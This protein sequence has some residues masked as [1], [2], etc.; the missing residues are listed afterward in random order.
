M[1]TKTE[2]KRDLSHFAFTCR[3]VW[4]QQPASLRMNPHK[5]LKMYKYLLSVNYACCCINET[6]LCYSVYMLCYSVNAQVKM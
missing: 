6:N 3:E 4:M 2:R 5:I 1:V